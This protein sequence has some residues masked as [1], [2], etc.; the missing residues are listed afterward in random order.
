MTLGPRL[1]VYKFLRRDFRHHAFYLLQSF[2][3]LRS[4]NKMF[5][6]DLWA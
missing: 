6:G 2:A 3:Q 1:S 4:V 5:V